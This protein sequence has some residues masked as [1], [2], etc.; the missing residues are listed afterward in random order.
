[1]YS[2]EI[3]RVEYFIDKD[4][5]FGQGI[6]IKKTESE[7]IDFVAELEKLGIGPHILYIRSMD[8]EF[9]WTQTKNIPFF[10]NAEKNEKSLSRVEYFIDKDPGLFNGVEIKSV[11]GEKSEFTIPCTDIQAGGHLLYIRSIDSDGYI[12]TV[13]TVPFYMKSTQPELVAIE[14]FIDNDPGKGKGK[15]I[16]LED[17]TE[18]FSSSFNADLTDV[19][20][21]SHIFYVRGLNKD[22]SWSSMENFP[23]EMIA[24][25][26][27]DITIETKYMVN[28]DKSAGMIRVIYIS[29]S[30][31]DKFYELF[32]LKGTLVQ[33]GKLNGNNE[34]YLIK[35]D[36]L[37]DG[38][39]IMKLM[40]KESIYSKRFIIKR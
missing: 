16:Y 34:S 35:C 5:G 28:Y 30:M 37:N 33:S 7:K 17:N 6:E 4:P 29:D 10:I 32:D 13:K 20:P 9:K 2:H 31:N 8:S 3:V 19:E 12:S 36:M 15:T 18:H 14:Y 22:G 27:G 40:Y 39:F 25:A 11:D 24:S 38:V 23:F 21:G 26:L 1:M